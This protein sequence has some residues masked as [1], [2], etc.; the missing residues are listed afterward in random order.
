MGAA[1]KAGKDR[2]GRA[3]SWGMRGNKDL[4]S[5]EACFPP[6]IFRD[7]ERSRGEKARR[8]VSLSASNEERKGG[9]LTTRCC[10]D[11]TRPLERGGKGRGEG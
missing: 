8:G 7:P 2:Q 9:Q 1:E 6:I 10:L 11:Q 3:R 4:K 5:D